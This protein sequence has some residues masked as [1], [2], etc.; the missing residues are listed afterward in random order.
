MNQVKSKYEAQ[1]YKEYNSPPVSISSS[2]APK[3]LV[4]QFKQETI[5]SFLNYYYCK[6]NKSGREWKKFVL[7]CHEAVFVQIF[8]NCITSVDRWYRRDFKEVKTQMNV[9]KYYEN[10][11]AIFLDICTRSEGGEDIEGNKN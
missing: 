10:N 6:N 11:E 5:F 2:E 4:G 3:F 9:F 1:N 8:R 7:V